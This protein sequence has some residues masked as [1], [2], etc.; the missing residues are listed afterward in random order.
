MLHNAFATI[1]RMRGDYRRLMEYIKEAPEPVKVEFA[2]LIRAFEDEQNSARREGRKDV[3][4]RGR[5]S[6]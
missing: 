2:R 1:H 6:F 5:G 4:I 3:L